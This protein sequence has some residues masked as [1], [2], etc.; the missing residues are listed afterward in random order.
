MDIIPCEN[1]FDEIIIFN[2][3]SHDAILKICEKILK[4]IKTSLQ[5]MGIELIVRKTAIRRL[6]EMAN[7]SEYGARDIQRT[8][9]REVLDIVAKQLL[10]KSSGISKIIVSSVSKKLKINFS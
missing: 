4:P 2:Q 9:K 8:I 5:Q 3:L 7:V 6:S 1:R 10:T